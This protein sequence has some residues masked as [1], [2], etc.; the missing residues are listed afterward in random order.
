MHKLK[1]LHIK[2]TSQNRLY[3]SEVPIIGL[4]GGI[5]TGKTTIC[6]ILKEN[7]HFIIDADKLVKEIYAQSK[8]VQFIQQECPSAVKSNEINFASLRKSFFTDS[9]LK[10]KIEQYIYSQLPAVFKRVLSKR[11]QQQVVIYDVPLLFEKK[12]NMLVD[13]TISIYVPV[14]TQF[15]R[16]LKRDNIT[17]DLANKIISSQMPVDEKIKL[18]DYVLDNTADLETLEVEVLNLMNKLTKK[19]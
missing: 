13:L 10:E 2:L 11:G 19:L 8:T 7:G 1:S 6:D 12:I 14:E 15:S 3:K 18:S 4:T 16:L 5:A 17:K 9:E